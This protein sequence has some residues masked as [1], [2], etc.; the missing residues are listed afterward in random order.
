MVS[1]ANERELVGC[2]VHMIH[3]PKKLLAGWAPE[4]GK[5]SAVAEKI[6]QAA[7]EVKR[8]RQ[9][10]YRHSMADTAIDA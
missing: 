5:A 8:G 7:S 1:K 9:F 3:V 4:P 6:C 10:S 2:R